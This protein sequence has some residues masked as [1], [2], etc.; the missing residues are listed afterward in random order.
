MTEKQPLV[1]VGIPTYNRPEGLRRTLE[2]ITNQTYKNLEII[3]S[4][5]CSS[6]TEVQKVAEEFVNKDN[7]IQ[8]FRQEENKGAG[9]NL[10]FVLKEATG[11]Y[12]MWAADNKMTNT[13]KH[14]TT[15]ND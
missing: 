13:L 6:D 10:K 8:Y 7:S 2:C 3:V 9:F 4:D 5:N 11:E 15:K 14:I 1:N 12:F